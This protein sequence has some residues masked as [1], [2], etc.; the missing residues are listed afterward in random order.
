[1]LL[2]FQHLRMHLVTP[3]LLAI[4]MA[5]VTL[6][7]PI[8]RILPFRQSTRNNRDLFLQP[9]QAI[10]GSKDLFLPL[11][12]GSKDLF[13]PFILGSRELWVISKT[14][15]THIRNLDNRCPIRLPIHLIHTRLIHKKN[16][17]RLAKYCSS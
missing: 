13:L 9:N 2:L 17:H 12:L 14:R 7:L 4:P 15:H 11:I 5:P 16:L 1:M 10:L 3:T 6:M 8:M